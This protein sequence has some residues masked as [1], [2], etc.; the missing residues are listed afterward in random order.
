MHNYQFNIATDKFEKTVYILAETYKD[1]L[2]KLFSTHNF[3]NY[4]FKG[5][6]Q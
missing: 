2:N 3:Y 5:I 1:A 4:Q 6:I